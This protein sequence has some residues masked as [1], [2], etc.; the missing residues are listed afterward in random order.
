MRTIKVTVEGR[1][2]I[3]RTGFPGVTGSIG[4]VGPAG[5]GMTVVTK[6]TTY[7]AAPREFVEANATTGPFTVTLPAAPINGIEVS[8]KKIDSSANVVTVLGAGGSTIDGD[9]NATLPDQWSWGTFIFNGTNWR[10]S[11]S[12]A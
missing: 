5:P 7:T 2:R 8:V 12:S 4:P 9:V 3:I 10:V 11:A 1:T 6:T